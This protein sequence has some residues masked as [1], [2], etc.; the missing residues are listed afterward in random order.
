ME[1][2]WRPGEEMESSPAGLSLYCS[3]ER[4]LNGGGGV[5]GGERQGVDTSSLQHGIMFGIETANKIV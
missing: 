1:L 4:G 5:G 3:G 2:Q